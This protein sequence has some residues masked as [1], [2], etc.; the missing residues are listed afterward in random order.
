[1][2]LKHRLISDAFRDFQRA[3]AVFDQPLYNTAR[4]INNNRV[5]LLNGTTNVLKYP[6]TDMV[7]TQESYELISELPGYD[8][9]DIKIELADDN[10]T[11]VLSGS[12]NETKTSTPPTTSTNTNE[13]QYSTTDNEAKSQQDQM[14]EKKEKDSQVAKSDENQWWVQERVIGSFTRS[15]ALPTPIDA[16]SIKAS[17]DNGVLKVVVPKTKETKEQSKRIDIE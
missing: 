17:F 10:R 2:S 14:V 4:L 13:E 1:M 6:A 16:E 9:K 15:F 3:L 8:K 7:E 12:T 11:L 5:P